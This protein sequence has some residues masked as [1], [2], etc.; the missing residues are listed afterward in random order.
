MNSCSAIN[1]W[2]LKKIR[3]IIR[4][5]FQFESDYLTIRHIFH[6]FLTNNIERITKIIVDTRFQILSR[7]FFF[8]RRGEENNHLPSFPSLFTNRL[9][10]LKY[11][12]IKIVSSIKRKQYVQPMQIIR[13]YNFTR[14]IHR[15][16]KKKEEEGKKKETKNTKLGTFITSL[17]RELRYTNRQ[18]GGSKKKKKKEK[19]DTRCISRKSHGGITFPGKKIRAIHWQ[20]Q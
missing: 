10:V 15:S 9:Y 13:S 1:C 2:I 20:S 16:S 6:S 3:S 11:S 14:W 18:P 12:R 4:I 5:I 8:K 17:S 7:V 19:T